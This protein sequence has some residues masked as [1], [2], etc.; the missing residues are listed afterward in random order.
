MCV[1]CIYFK[2]PVLNCC[3]SLVPRPRYHVY[4]YSLIYNHV[5]CIYNLHNSSIIIPTTE[6]LSNRLI[7]K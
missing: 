3:S 2:N 7:L 4:L 5:I 1:L 6:V